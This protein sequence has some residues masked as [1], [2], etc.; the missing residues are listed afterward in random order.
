[1][2]FKKKE[3]IADQLDDTFLALARIPF[4]Q[5]ANI[6]G[7]SYWYI[8]ATSLKY[9]VEKLNKHV[10]SRNKIRKFFG[11]KT[12]D[13]IIDNFYDEVM[14]QYC[15]EAEARLQGTGWT[16]ESLVAE[17]AELVYKEKDEISSVSRK[18]LWVSMGI[19]FMIMCPLMIFCSIVGIGLANTII[20]AINSSTLS[21]ILS[22]RIV[23]KLFPMPEKSS[24]V[25]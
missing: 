13:E 1:M 15:S 9:D 22:P 24:D 11:L 5:A 8:R 18:R 4:S 12:E 25:I 7:N 17:Y 2:W 23:E 20:V 6:A 14:E 16:G 10:I 3:K 19:S 21:S